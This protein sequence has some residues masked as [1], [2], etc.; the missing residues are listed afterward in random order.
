MQPQ[1]VKKILKYNKYLEDKIIKLKNGAV[2]KKK[3]RLELGKDYH[4][5]L[6]DLV[7][8][9]LQKEDHYDVDYWESLIMPGFWK[10]DNVWD[11]I[12]KRWNKEKASAGANAYKYPMNH[13]EGKPLRQILMLPQKHRQAKPKDNREQRIESTLNYI[14]DHFLIFEH[15]EDQELYSAHKTRGEDNSPLWKKGTE[16]IDLFEEFR[17]Y[18]V[19]RKLKDETANPLADKEELFDN[20]EKQFSAILDEISRDLELDKTNLTVETEN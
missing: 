8:L 13:V 15:K 3:S 11:G 14:W 17:N 12:L 10:E 5:A 18:D 2:K 4:I 16:Y 19:H 1:E 7:H 9:I 20:Y 6:K